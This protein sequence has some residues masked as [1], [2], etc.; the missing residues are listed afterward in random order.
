M[1]KISPLLLLIIQ[2]YKSEISCDKS[3]LKNIAV[4]IKISLTL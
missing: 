1:K 2:N 4:N 3:L